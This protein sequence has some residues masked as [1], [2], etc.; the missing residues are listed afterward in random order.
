MSDSPGISGRTQLT[1]VIGWPIAHSVSPAMHNAAFRALGLDWCYLPFAVHPA[2]LPDALRGIRAL[3]LRGINATVPHKE[4]LLALVDSLTPAA[5]AIG[6]VNTV[7]LAN[8]TIVGHNTDAQGFLRALG[9]VGFSPAGSTA[10]ILG[11]GGAARAVAY[12]LATAGAKVKVLNRTPGRAQALAAD[13][14]A[15]L[16]GDLPT[17]ASL[18]GDNLDENILRREAKQA[19]LV[20]NATTLGMWPLV[21]SSPW[22]PAVPFPSDAL[23]FDL[24]YNPRQTRFCQL[25]Q[26]SG[27]QTLDGLRML[28]HQGAEA[29]ELW[30]GS[31][32][33]IGVM[34]AACTAILGGT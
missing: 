34:I 17:G 4:A 3:G 25:A 11:A 2:R 32:P 9:D 8:D 33:P 19:K 20:V 27:A 12:A 23:L 30:T 10:L 7:S 29:F 16:A 31:V 15:R 26:A 14:G 21:D 6:A 5:R 22:P 18:V 1:G 13:L 28:V 24:V